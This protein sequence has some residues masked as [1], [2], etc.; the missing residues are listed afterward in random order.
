MK[1][2]VLKDLSSCCEICPKNVA[3]HPYIG[4]VLCLEQFGKL[5]PD[6]MLHTLSAVAFDCLNMN[7]SSK[8]CWLCVE[9]PGV[10]EGSMLPRKA[11]GKCSNA[12]GVKQGES[13]QAT[14]NDSAMIDI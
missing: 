4:N 13:E 8:L 14:H 9:F 7:P 11:G 6:K 3:D 12:S 2:T 10:Y 1:R 5:F